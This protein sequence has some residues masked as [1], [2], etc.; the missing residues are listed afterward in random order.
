[1]AKQNDLNAVVYCNLMMDN[2]DE[3][4]DKRMRTLMEIE[5]DKAGLARAYNKNVRST[6]LQVGELV[7][8]TIL[9]LETK[10]VTFRKWSPSWE[11]PYKIVKVIAGNS[12]KMESL[13][14]T[15]LPRAL[16]SQYLKKCYPSD[17]QDVELL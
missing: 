2:I 10:D 12:N 15:R 17:W 3:A 13:E 6:S 9:P 8:K 5:K 4:T 14:G 7:W 16:N 1:L 11:V